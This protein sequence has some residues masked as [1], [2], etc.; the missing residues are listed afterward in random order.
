MNQIM[1]IMAVYPGTQFH[2]G[3]IMPPI[4]KVDDLILSAGNSINYNRRISVIFSM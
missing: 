1:W 3:L 2:H 4:L